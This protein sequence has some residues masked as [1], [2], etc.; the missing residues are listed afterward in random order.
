MFTQRCVGADK[1]SASGCY[2]KVRGVRGKTVGRDWIV[3]SAMVNRGFDDDDVQFFHRHTLPEIEG[4]S[5]G[6]L[7]RAHVAIIT[8]IESRWLCLFKARIGRHCA[9]Q[10]HLQR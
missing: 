2:C 3:C 4:R 8:T 1:V 9:K 7:A 6:R 5:G 10:F